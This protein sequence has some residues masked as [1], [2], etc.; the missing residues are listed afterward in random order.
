ME[1]F[2]SNATDDA[3][4]HTLCLNDRFLIDEWPQSFSGRWLLPYQARV[5]DTYPPLMASLYMLKAICPYVIDTCFQ[6]Y[7]N[8]ICSVPVTFPLSLEKTATFIHSRSSNCTL[9]VNTPHEPQSQLPTHST[10][11][12]SATY[13]PWKG[14]GWNEK[15]LEISPHPQFWRGVFLWGAICSSSFAQP[16]ERPSPMVGAKSVLYQPFKE[17]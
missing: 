13:D 2:V 5:S 11:L 1:D 9:L 12:P 17:L 14:G 8:H 6:L 15:F 10:I 4:G 16:P 7:G 3:D